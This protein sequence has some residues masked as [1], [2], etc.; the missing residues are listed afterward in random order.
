MN[1]LISS[2]HLVGFDF[3]GNHFHKLFMTLND[4][5]LSWN[6]INSITELHPNL[7]KG[8]NSYKHAQTNK[9]LCFI[10]FSTFFF[11][12]HQTF[13]LQ[14][15]NYFISLTLYSLWMVDWI[16]YCMT[17]GES[18]FSNQRIQFF[19]AFYSFLIK[20]QKKKNKLSCVKSVKF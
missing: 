8:K 9:M 14:M 18:D 7:K 15:C 20:N 5:R 12:F 3:I 11:S 6:D 2:I 10:Y 13:K 19:P 4:N 16:E 17:I 1:K